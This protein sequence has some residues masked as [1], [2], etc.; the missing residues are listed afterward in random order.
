MGPTVAVRMFLWQSTGVVEVL[1]P[2]KAEAHLP[3]VLL[4]CELCAVPLRQAAQNGLPGPLLLAPMCTQ[5][6]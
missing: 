5:S 4:D 6:Q 2:A 3:L 1:E